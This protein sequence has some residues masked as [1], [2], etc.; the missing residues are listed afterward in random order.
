MYELY[1]W[2]L[3]IFYSWFEFQIN[4]RIWKEQVNKVGALRKDFRV[5]LIDILVF[6][7]GGSDG[8]Y[9]LSPE[10]LRFS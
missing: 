10:T 6:S 7:E 5:F 4:S 8:V 9:F 3:F 1:A 2:S